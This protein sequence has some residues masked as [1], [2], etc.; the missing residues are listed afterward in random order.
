[1]HVV[2][3]TINFSLNGNLNELLQFSCKCDG[4]L[5]AT[6]PIPTKLIF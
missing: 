1:M 6:F 3:E 5:Q 2:K 4:A